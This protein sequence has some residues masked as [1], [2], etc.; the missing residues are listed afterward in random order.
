MREEKKNVRMGNPMENRQSRCVIYVITA[1]VVFAML[2]MRGMTAS[3]QVVYENA[4]GYEVVIEDDM[5]LLT[6]EQILMLQQDMEPITGYG[7]VAFKSF[8]S[9][10]PTDS[11]AENYYEG[12]WGD[13]SG[14]V[15]VVDMYNRTL[16]IYSEGAIYRTVTK[17]YA[18]TITDNVYTYAT[19]E[20]YYTCAAEVYRQM[21]TLLEGGRVAQPMKYMSNAFLAVILSFVLLY[22]FVKCVSAMKQPSESELLKGLEMAQKVND[23]DVQFVSESKIYSPQS[24]GGGSHGG[25]SRGGGGGGSRGGGSRGGGG[26]HRF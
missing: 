24:S 21:Y 20:D 23:V 16:Y 3:A 10:Y 12:L 13:E 19:N 8:S 1:L 14:T 2:V 5:E 4:N 26:G 22:F 25:G 18:N 7:N 17:S 9:F 11:F 15:F 6:S